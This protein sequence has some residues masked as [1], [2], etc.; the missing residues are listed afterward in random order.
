MGIAGKYRYVVL[1]SAVLALL[2]LVAALLLGQ[3]FA[4]A[5]AQQTPN[6]TMQEFCEHLQ[7]KSPDSTFG[8]NFGPAELEYQAREI[9]SCEREFMCLDD[10]YG[11]DVDTCIP[12]TSINWFWGTDLVP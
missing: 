8:I 9:Y 1:S 5:S 2:A 4:T 3:P 10:P 7:Q 12:Y 6:R 11:N